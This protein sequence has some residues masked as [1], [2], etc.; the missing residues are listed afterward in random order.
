MMRRSPFKAEVRAHRVA[1]PGPQTDRAAATNH[2]FRLRVPAALTTAL[3]LVLTS[4]LPSPGATYTDSE[5]LIDSWETD[6]GL[7]EN[8]V[9]AM[10]QAPDG[11][12]WFGTFNGLVHFDGARFTVYDPANT[13]GLPSAGI[14]HLHLDTSGRLYVST[15][16]G[17]VVSEAPRWTKFQPV[18]GWSGDYVRTF[19]ENAGLLCVTS[20]DGRVFREQAGHFEEL[21]EPPGQRGSGR[22]G[23]VD[24]A[25]RIW[26]AQPGHFFGSWDG[27]QWQS[28]KLAPELAPGLLSLTGLRDGRLLVV[29]TN[30]LLRLEEEQVLSR[31][32]LPHPLQEAWSAYEDLG[33]TI[34]ISSRGLYRIGPSGDVRYF[35]T[36]NGLTYDNVRFTFQDRERNLWVGTSGGGL[37]RFKLRTFLSYGP[38]SGLIERNVKTVAEDASGR[39]L[40]GTYGGGLFAW[41][42]GRLTALPADEQP[43]SHWIQCLL[44]DREGHL[45]VGGY[46]APE[47]DL[48]LTVFTPAGRRSVPS[49]EAGNSNVRALFQD[50]RG[51]VWTGGNRAVS[52]YA[53]GRFVV[54][55][56][57]KE[58]SMGE[59]NCFAEDPQTGIIWAGGSEGLFQYAGGQWQEVRDAARKALNGI[60]CLRA[61]PDGSLWVGGAG[62]GLQQLNRGRWSSITP[63]HGLPTPNITCILEDDSGHWWLG[64]NRGVVRAAR[65]D[66]LRVADGTMARLPCQVFNLSDGMASIECTMGMQPSSLKDRQGRL[67][68]A[69]LKGVAMVDPHRLQLNTN[70]PPVRLRDVSY[71]NRRGNTVTI[72]ADELP[73]PRLSASA[74]SLP[75][76]TFP[77]GSSQLRARFAV[78]SFVAP[79]KVRLE[80]RLERNQTPLLVSEGS[81]RYVTAQWLPPGNYR[82]RVTAA[83]NDGLWNEEGTVVAFAVQPFFWQTLW[84]RALAV[85][86]F[87]G[88]IV[89]TVSSLHRNRL[90]RTEDRLRQQQALAESEARFRRIVETTR[91]WIWA[92]DKHGRHTYSNPAVEQILGYAPD[93]IARL[94]LSLLHPDDRRR[95]EAELP[96][97]IRRKEGWTGRIMRWRHRDG[98]YRVLESSAIPALDAQGQLVGFQGANHDITER[99]RV[100]EALA[101]NEATLRSLFRAVP[102]GIGILQGRTIRSV[103][104][105]ICEIVGYSPKQL[106]GQESRILY[107][108]DA[109]YERVGRALYDHLW[110]AGLSH[111]ETRFLRS[112]GN[113]R[114][115]SL[116]VAPLQADDPAMGVAVVIQDIT[117][118]KRAAQILRESEAMLRSIFS[119]APIAICM[120]GPDRTLHSV[121]DRAVEMFGYSADELLGSP[122]TRLYTSPEESERVGQILYRDLWSKNITR[123]ECTLRRK[124]GTELRA[125][126]SAAPLHPDDPHAG[127]VVTVLDV[128][129]WRRIEEALRASED[130]FAKAFHTSP[131]A[132]NINRL[133]DGMFVDIND[134]FTALTGYTMED[135]RGK[136][137]TDLGL[138]ANPEDRN[139]LTASLRERG[140][141]SNLEALFRRKDGRVDTGLMSAK[142]IEIG[143]EPCIISIT[144]DISERKRVEEA[145]RLS[146]EEKTALL[147][148]VHHRVKNNLQIVVSLLNLQAVQT[149]D[150]VTLNTLTDTQN[151]VRSMA[152]LHETLY[153]SGNLARVNLASYVDE[154]CAHLFRSCGSAAARIRLQTQ[155]VG[156]SLNLDQAVPCGLIIN[157]LVSNALQHAFPNQQPG[158]ITVALTASP[159]GQ[160]TLAV[161][162]DGTGLPPEATLRQSKTLG[163]QLVRALA[164][165]LGGTADFAP[166][167]GTTCHITF[168]SRDPAL[169]SPPPSPPST[170]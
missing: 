121:N 27:R 89:V 75:Q 123:T 77:P 88:G 68:F 33:G 55:P 56:A 95:V 133:S 70:P 153:R 164:Q 84:F 63:R 147:K 109:E 106:I 141:V 87:G 108:S 22:L 4:V 137:S 170:R 24:P 169:P 96:E 90:R 73:D 94:N 1:Q 110:D 34:W 168:T 2:A 49:A 7:P 161:S 52:V 50:S 118:E 60:L 143:G 9:T 81:E 93:E 39:I 98:T 35:C 148:E 85:L 37:M 156:V 97:K 18:R 144:R 8:S 150:P 17:L 64:S 57:P 38:E 23:H 61:E 46:A 99:K 19:S 134:G 129:E 157:E 21:P 122:P 67:W 159:L 131:D 86:L 15:Y 107:E 151:R 124:D 6:Q 111:V 25:G 145:I 58:V 103:N 79:E 130:K 53:D 149:A 66:V 155:A 51:R 54:P 42:Q 167:P 65:E 12:L 26:V 115:I 140:E 76:L 71:V 126:V 30:E 166:G 117:E 102:V 91:E 29:T 139:R 45:W 62:V 158:Q 160:V 165:Q 101:R 48:A 92:V 20:F 10:V 142:V 114:E 120:L 13:P 36:T 116:H 74:G 132:I 152:L 3:S 69:T 80:Y 44:P 83:N 125:L 163:L 14:V 32:P 59:V 135:V 128:T 41:M 72:H 47:Q 28:A 31:Q 104:D 105:R 136:T 40:V 100:E 43:A 82:L 138:W 154:L 113:A 146:L 16:R 112:D 78:P 119:A 5:Y 127:A 11:S 162:D